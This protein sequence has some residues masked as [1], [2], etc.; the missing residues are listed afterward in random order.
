LQLDLS[1]LKQQE[2]FDKLCP[3]QEPPA[4][5]DYRPT[6][7]DFYTKVE[8]QQNLH[9]I[10]EKLLAENGELHALNQDVQIAKEHLEARIK[11]LRSKVMPSDS[12]ERSKFD[13]CGEEG[14]AE[15]Q[16]DSYCDPSVDI[17]M[18]QQ[19]NGCE[20]ALSVIGYCVQELKQG[21]ESQ[22]KEVH[23]MIARH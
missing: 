12:E 16:E 9:K 2:A 23:E 14:E 18:A 6:L 13:F 20:A 17:E 4:T 19:D 1:E 5:Q 15:M 3:N 21:E 10:C 7:S 8:L 22:K 11:E